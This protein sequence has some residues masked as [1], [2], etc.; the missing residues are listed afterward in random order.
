VFFAAV[1]APWFI[2]DYIADR[3]SETTECIR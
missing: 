1:Y 2:K 3:R